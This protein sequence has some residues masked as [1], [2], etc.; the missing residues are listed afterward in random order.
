[1]KQSRRGL[2][3]VEVVIVIAVLI[4][5]ALIFRGAILAYATD[6]L[7]SVFGDSASVV[8][9]PSGTEDAG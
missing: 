5:I 8:A 7:Q 1:M 9:G 2:G 3:T 4:T 6:I